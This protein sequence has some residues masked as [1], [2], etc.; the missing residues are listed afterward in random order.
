[1]GVERDRGRESFAQGAW[2]RAYTD[3]SA[4]APAEGLPAEDLER[5]ASAAYLA[6][7]EPESDDAWAR[8]HQEWLR[9]GDPRG[10][11]RCAF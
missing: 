8:A 10:A 3:L 11:A 7:H 2:E 4:A 5:L 6:G 1:M 9:V